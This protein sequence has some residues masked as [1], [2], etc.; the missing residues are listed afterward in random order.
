VVDDDGAAGGQ[1]D[2]AAVGGFDL[3][4]DLKRENSGTS[5]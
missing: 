5:S 1:G 4:L 2:I 3:V